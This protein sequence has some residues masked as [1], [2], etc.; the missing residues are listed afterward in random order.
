M[1][2]QHGRHWHDIMTFDDSWFCPNTYHEFIWQPFHGKLP[3]RERNTIQSEK[4]TLTTVWNPNGFHVINVL[5]KGTKFNPDHY[6]TDVLILLAEWLKTQV[7]RTDQ[8]LIA[9]AGNARCYIVKMSLDFL[10]HNALS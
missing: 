9:H 7:G 8:K 6:I 3:E 5:S 1:K 2:N 10:E 4:M